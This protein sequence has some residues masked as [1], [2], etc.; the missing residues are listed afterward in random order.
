[1]IPYYGTDCDMHE[2]I[3]MKNYKIEDAKV[4][5]IYDVASSLDDLLVLY[6]RKTPIPNST[7]P[8]SSSLTPLSPRSPVMIAPPDTLA[9]TTY[10]TLINTL[11]SIQTW[12]SSNPDGRNVWQNYQRGGQGEPFYV[13][14]EGF[15]TA[16]WRTV[17]LGK[18]VM[19]L[20]WGHRGCD[21]ISVGLGMGDAWRVEKDGE[22]N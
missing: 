2:R 6:R 3:A 1:M 4:G 17:E 21:I 18:E 8:P 5:L 15:E 10:K 16:I 14:P 9:S 19:S 12:K 22:W 20:K 11:D 7:P 13:D